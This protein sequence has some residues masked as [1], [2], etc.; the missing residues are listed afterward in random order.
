MNDYVATM[1][2]LVGHRPMLVP[3]V[4]A[5][6]LNPQGEVLLM[7]RLDMPCWCL[8][9]GS[10]ELGE[11]ALDAL[12]REVAE[13]TSL[14]VLEA[15]PMG[16][17]SGPSQRFAYPNGDEVYCFAIAFVVRRREG[18]PRADGVEGSELRFFPLPELPQEL[19][20]LH[21]TTIEDYKSYRG[22]FLLR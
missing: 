11:T 22:T 6:I 3:G 7:R 19:V 15:E 4:R 12:R 18:S 9:S 16:L 10:V 5:L 2:Q 1:R 13:E 14:A 17:Y 8:P 21:K 20:P